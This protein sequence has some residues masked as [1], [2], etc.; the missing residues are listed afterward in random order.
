MNEIIKK[1]LEYAKA[2][3][4]A[5][6]VLVDAG[7]SNYCYQ[8]AVLHCHQA[9]EKI[10]KTVIISR[11]GEP[12]RIHDLIKLS[13]DV[14][15]KLPVRFQNYIAKLNVHY[16]PSRYPDIQYKFPTLKYN[17]KIAEYHFKN[18]EELFAWVEKKLISEN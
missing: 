1:W 8:S 15:F 4:E 9:I 5:A 10:L 3:L 14:N 16:Q 6:K 13:H 2:D 12:K 17:F 18:T 11:G 7:K